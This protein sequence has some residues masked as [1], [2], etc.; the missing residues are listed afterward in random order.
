MKAAKFIKE[1]PSGIEILIKFE[2]P[3]N[4]DSLMLKILSGKEILTKPVQSWKAD[5]P[6][7]YTLLGI[8]ISF[9]LEQP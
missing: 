5:F 6:I 1:T 4:V 9:K 2:Q 8:E 3:W 7:L